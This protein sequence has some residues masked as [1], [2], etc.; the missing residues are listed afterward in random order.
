[1]HSSSEVLG[2]MNETNVARLSLLS[3]NANLLPFHVTEV[4]RIT[5]NIHQNVL[6]QIPQNGGINFTKTTHQISL[7]TVNGCNKSFPSWP[8]L[9]HRMLDTSPFLRLG[10]V[11]AILLF[12]FLHIIKIQTSEFMPAISPRPLSK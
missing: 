2:L 12:L 4:C 8:G 10:L 1:M 7:R 6:T 5:A 11:P 9:S 3:D